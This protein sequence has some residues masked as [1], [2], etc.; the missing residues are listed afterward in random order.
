VE[1]ISRKKEIVLLPDHSKYCSFAARSLAK[2]FISHT[3]IQCTT[4]DR[5]IVRLQ[6][7]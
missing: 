1:E 2:K 7:F 3:Q 4:G 6:T 5:E